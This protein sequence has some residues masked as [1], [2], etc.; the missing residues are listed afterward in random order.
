MPD[1]L[2]FGSRDGSA[3]A[4]AFFAVI[5]GIVGVAAAR[6]MARSDM[7]AMLARV[8]ALLLWVG[9][10]GAIYAS[11]ISGF[12]DLAIDESSIRLDYLPPGSQESVAFDRI[13]SV[14]TTPSYR[15]RDRLVI[16][17]VD[18]RR[19]ESTPAPRPDVAAAAV[20]LR[21][22]VRR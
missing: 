17:D 14:T 8:I 21:Q 10:V 16:I 3:M 18:G 7:P 19:F 6:Q 13:A 20:R 9:P 22:A 15:G 12:Y 5:F 11:S 1:V 4:L 2:H